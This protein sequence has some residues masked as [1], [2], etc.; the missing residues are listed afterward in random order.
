M[1]GNAPSRHF[2]Y[3]T[4]NIVPMEMKICLLFATLATTQRSRA[5]ETMMVNLQ[6]TL[7]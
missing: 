1:I 4:G 7:E 6:Q 2:H 5:H 3:H